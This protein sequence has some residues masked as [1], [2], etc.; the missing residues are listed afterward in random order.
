MDFADA[1]TKADHAYWLSGIEVGDAVRRPGVRDDR[2][3]LRG[4]RRRRPGG[5]RHAERRRHSSAAATSAALGYQRQAQGV[6]QACRGRR[7]RNRLVIDGRNVATVTIDPDPRARHVRRGA[8]RHDRL[9]DDRPARG[10]FRHPPGVRAVGCVR[11]ARPAALE[12][13]AQRSARQ[14]PPRHRGDR[15]RDRLPL[16]QRPRRPG[17]VRR[18]QVAVARTS[19]RRC[20]FLT[21]S[22]QARP[23]ALVQ[24]LRLAAHASS[25]ASARARCRGR[26]AR[27]RGCRAAATS[28]GSAR[29]TP[30]ARSRPA[31]GGS[32][33][34]RS[35]SADAASVRRRR[36][37]SGL[38]CSLSRRDGISPRSDPM[39][40]DELRVFLAEQKIVSVAHDRPE[41]PAAPDAALVRHRRR[42]SCAAG[43]SPSRRR[44]RTSSATRTRRSRSRPASST[45]S[46]AA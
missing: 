43:R 10:L 26:S 44:P 25:A 35:G 42:R 29:S 19:G 22:G 4:L 16:R 36:S 39:T 5:D 14:P 3:A 2:R 27:V 34:R 7:A 38:V 1:G 30:A 8:R 17:T 40:D 45:R 18:V 24:P 33:A 23:G 31:R 11:R 20:R 32:R 6:G 12:R 13:L 9:A 21:R 28:C 41:R 37:G 46:C 15:P